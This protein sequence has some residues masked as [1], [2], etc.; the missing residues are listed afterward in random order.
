MVPRQAGFEL[1]P[2]CDKVPVHVSWRHQLFKRRVIRP[3][4][5]VVSGD[6]LVILCLDVFPVEAGVVIEVAGD[7]SEL[8]LVYRTCK[9]GRNHQQ[10]RVDHRH[11]AERQDYVERADQHS[12]LLLFPSDN[13][14]DRHVIPEFRVSGSKFQV[15]KVGGPATWNVEHGTLNHLK[16]PLS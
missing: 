15:W 7:E 4:P 11:C 2:F 9:G 8:V 16:L 12:E 14:D 5:G 3:E 10:K 1:P 6:I 13:G